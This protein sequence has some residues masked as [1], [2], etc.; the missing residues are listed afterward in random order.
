VQNPFART[1]GDRRGFPVAPGAFPWVGHLPALYRDLP[2]A[3]RRLREALGPLFW[4]RLGSRT[5]MLVCSGP[6]GLEAFQSPAFSS[7]HLQ[8]GASLVA[9]SSMLAQ[10]GDVHRRM[11]GAM[12]RPFLPRGLAAGALARLTASALST[13]AERWLARGR[14][15]VLPE[16]Q[17]VTLS[18]IFRALGV[19]DADL[20]AF[21]VQYRDLLL[22][23][24]GV[25]LDFPGSPK[26]RAA[27][28]RAWIDAR[29]QALIERARARPDDGSLLAALAR[30]TDEQ[31]RA[32]ADAELCDNLR[33]LVLA[34]HETISATIAWI[35]I[36]LGTRP[37][38]WASLLG[39]VPPSAAVPT[40]IEEARRFP[41]AEALFRETV[42][43]HPPF[44]VITRLTVQDAV[45]HGRTVPART[46]V[47]VDLG[48]VAR[49]PALFEQP[50]ELRPSRWLGRGGPPSPIEISQFGAGA[51]FCLGYHLAWLEA[52]Q[53]SVALART[54]GGAGR[55]P[56][57]PGKRGQEPR[58]VY[59][60]TEHP[61]PRIDVVFER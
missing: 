53:F 29:L 13:L 17:E 55:R 7:T 40:T 43:L 46:T 16:V 30:G 38:L 4:I 59:V 61:D 25:D 3:L 24:L 14:A 31:G 51:H 57:L 6:A 27:R 28:A 36:Q 58:A 26:R 8:K 11:R 56:T 12:S 49:D 39:E 33:L 15:H 18:I 47:A 48:S 34:G 1:P 32:L 60:P 21:R 5:W 44:G 10:D 23:N 42:R 20:P 41:F 19:D 50:D 45:L 52:V 37:D 54:L 22:S 2:C 35:V 9:G